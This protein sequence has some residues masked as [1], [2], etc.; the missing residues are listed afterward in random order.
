MNK[1]DRNKKLIK[2][3]C[4][5]NNW[6]I[7]KITS[8]ALDG[9][10]DFKDNKHKYLGRTT[11]RGFLLLE[12]DIWFRKDNPFVKDN[13]KMLFSLMGNT[14]VLLEKGFVYKGGK[15]P[16]ICKCGKVYYK[17]LEKIKSSGVLLCKQCSSLNRSVQKIQKNKNQNIELLHNLEFHVVKYINS[18]SILVEDK[19]G[20]KGYISMAKPKLK[21][22]Q[23]RTAKEYFFY[24]LEVFAQS[25]G[26]KCRVVNWETTQHL[27]NAGLICRCEC[28]D[29]FSVKIESFKD[30]KMLCDKCSSVMSRYERQTES[31][32]VENKI[33]YEKQ[34]R[35]DDCRNPHTNY[36]LP[37]DF[38]LP[39]IKICI[40]VDGE[41]HF[42]SIPFGEKSFK[43]T[44]YNDSIKDIYCK[45]KNIKLI[46]IP[47]WEYKTKNYEHILCS[48]L[49]ITNVN[50]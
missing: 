18:K 3:K 46:R 25:C 7:L 13:I 37:F 32:L 40:E 47:F 45:K 16:L 14:S 41:G 19:N 28:G 8:Y 24:N 26:Y 23:I 34:K 43:S 50:T 2:E 17:S 38:Y 6:E 35:F 42:S 10:V 20:Y 36:P 21:P 22:F 44:Q 5:C 4:V 49:H 30:G 9:I 1:K 48:K 33:F 12:K 27:G 39:E 11:V 29:L 15:I 31:F